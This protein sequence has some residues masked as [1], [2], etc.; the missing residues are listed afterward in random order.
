MFENCAIAPARFDALELRTM[1]TPHDLAVDEETSQLL[2]HY[3]FDADTF[4]ELCSRLRR[5]EAGA[6][7]NRIDQVARDRLGMKF[8]E[9]AETVVIRP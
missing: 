8:P 6:E 4:A 9:G 3:G 1:G 5:G 2:Q 7:S